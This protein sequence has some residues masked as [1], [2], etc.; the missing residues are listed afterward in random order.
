VRLADCVIKEFERWSA[1]QPLEFE[2]T[3]EVLATM[4]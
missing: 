1:G 2:V 4:G 3:V